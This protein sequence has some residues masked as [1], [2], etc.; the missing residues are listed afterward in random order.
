MLR[1]II[2]A[3]LPLLQ[4]LQR[5]GQLL[6]TATVAPPAYSS[7]S[8]SSNGS[9]DTGNDLN[10][11]QEFI[12]VQHDIGGFLAELVTYV[13]A[14]QLATGVDV[15]MPACEL[16]RDP[17][18]SELLLQQL[19]GFTELLYKEHVAYRQQ[20]RQQQQES[21]ADSSSS[22]SRQLQQ[23][24]ARG[25]KQQH[26]ADLLPIPAFHRRTDML[27]VLPGGQAYLDAAA[28]F[29]APDQHQNGTNAQLLAKCLHQVH[30]L[31]MSIIASL[32]H[33]LNAQHAGLAVDA[34]APL[35]SAAAVRLV[36]QLQLLAASFVQRQRASKQQQLQRQQQ[37]PP[38]QQL[39]GAEDLEEAEI[40]LM[41]TNFLLQLQIRTVVQCTGSCLPPEVLQQA[42]LQL[43]Q[44][45]AAPLQQ[46]QL[47]SSHDK[48]NLLELLD[49]WI[50]L[51][52]TQQLFALR[53]AAAGMFQPVLSTPGEPC[54]AAAAAAAVAA[55]AN[56]KDVVSAPP[57]YY[58][59]SLQAD[60]QTSGRCFVPM[61]IKPVRALRNAT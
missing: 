36:L 45:L 22:S 46:L 26:R 52:I 40:W 12:H 28:A 25:A 6:P 61:P 37:Q 17:A 47:C 33:T 31:Q 42:G 50:H 11:H 30:A 49:V 55:V 21:A 35:L 1:T 18:V 10:P 53:A 13:D 48:D 27:Q 59:C 8:S 4:Q 51:R 58:W 54:S 3:V 19:A 2:P 56:G 5:C 29:A 32:S 57:W 60:A 9:R 44:A 7:S 41:R 39:Q 15:Q 43:L 16:L 34:T 24:S 20:Q 23:H 14:Q 38:E